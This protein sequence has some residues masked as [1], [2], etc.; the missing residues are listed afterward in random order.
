VIGIWQRSRATSLG[1][2]RRA[3]TRRGRNARRSFRTLANSI[4]QL[5]WMANSDGW[6]VWYNGSLVRI[7]GHD[8]GA[9]GGDGWQR[10]HD[11]AVLRT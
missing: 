7:H 9:D 8:A 4:P 5:V 3:G 2:R 1:R 10:V 6:I 11:P